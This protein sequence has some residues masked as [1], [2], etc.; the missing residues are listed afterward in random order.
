MKIAVISD[1]HGSLHYFD[2]AMTIIGDYDY[3]IHC[4]DVLP[5]GSS[6]IEGGYDMQALAKRINAL[7]NVY[8]ALGNGDFISEN[9]MPDAHFE[10]ELVLQLGD[11][12]FFVTHSHLYSRMSMIMK[13]M[14]QG[15]H[16]LCYG[17]THV[18]ELDYYDNLLILNPGS[19]SLPRDGSPSCAI[20]AEGIVSIY[21]V[22]S[23]AKIAELP[24]KKDC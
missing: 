4:G 8:F 17:H 20:I 6:I 23:G 2:K 7:H 18:K 5:S 13:A 1:T 10:K 11:Y 22:D 16:I 15:A 12:K 9:Y 14:E 24:I 21:N 19:V 3:L